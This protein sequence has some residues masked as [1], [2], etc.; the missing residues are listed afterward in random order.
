MLCGILVRPGIKPMSL[1]MEAQRPNHWPPS[2]SPPGLNGCVFLDKNL[3]GIDIKL[4][5][6]PPEQT[7][8]AGSVSPLAVWIKWHWAWR[9]VTSWWHQKPCCWCS[10]LA[11]ENAGLM[12]P[13]GAVVA[14]ANSILSW[15]V[16]EAF[17]DGP[18]HAGG[19]QPFP[20]GPRFW[21][22]SAVLSPPGRERIKIHAK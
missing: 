18:I 8:E 12:E 9:R 15:R 10:A 7:L 1:Q 16:S 2:K 20:C 13:E 6:I 4:C 22:C 14:R 11:L 17:G 19:G 5:L 3:A 21:H